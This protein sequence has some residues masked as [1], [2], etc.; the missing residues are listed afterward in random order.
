[1]VI[2]GKLEDYEINWRLRRLRVRETWCMEAREKKSRRRE[3]EEEI[4]TKEKYKIY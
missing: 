3:G 1:M 2:N 4:Y